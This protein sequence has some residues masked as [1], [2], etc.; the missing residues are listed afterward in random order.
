M[1]STPPDDPTIQE[2]PLL[3]ADEIPTLAPSLSA[4]SAQP[5]GTAFVPGYEVLEVLGR[6]GM[7]IVYRARQVKA[8]RVVALKMILAGGHASE[9]DVQRFC[10][11]AMA[12]A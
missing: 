9:A 5:A 8:N 10:T 6:G 4:P 3:P 11:E 1:P 7:G 2:P 12:I